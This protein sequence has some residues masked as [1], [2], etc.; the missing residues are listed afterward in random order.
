MLVLTGWASN[1][2]NTTLNTPCQCQLVCFLTNYAVQTHTKAYDFFWIIQYKCRH[3]Q[4][5]RRT[6]RHRKSEPDYYQWAHNTD[7]DTQKHV[8]IYS[9]LRKSELANLKIVTTRHT[10]FSNYMV[11][12]HCLC[13]HV[14]KPFHINTFE[15][16]RRQSQDCYYG[17]LAIN[18][19][20]TYYWNK[21]ATKKSRG[22]WTLIPMEDLK[23]DE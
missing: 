22:M 17:L 8:R 7:A 19:H 13:T 14:L 16:L 15:R 6:H 23:P 12:T 20:I 1:K 2:D 9:P 21:S 11:H 3:S 4:A 18:G 10:F 5:C